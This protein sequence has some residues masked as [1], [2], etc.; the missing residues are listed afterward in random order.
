MFKLI[1]MGES[2]NPQD[3]CA[4]PYFS[5]AND[6]P[7]AHPAEAGSVLTF[8]FVEAFHKPLLMSGFGEVQ[9]VWL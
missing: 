6:G 5:Q 1:R 3:R 9:C 7:F 8:Q 2:S 4:G